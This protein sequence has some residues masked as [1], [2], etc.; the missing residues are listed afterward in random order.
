MREPGDGLAWLSIKELAALCNVSEKTARRWKQGTICPPP[1]ARALIEAD[2]GALDPKW[3]GWHL[4]RGVLLS[5]DG[6][7]ASPGDIM[8]L[9]F[10][11]L[12]VSTHRTENVRLRAENEEL[13]QQ[14]YPAMEDQPAPDDW[15]VK[16]DYG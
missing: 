8:A 4:R 12:Q 6:V 2:L 16:I 9:P 5:P 7:E 3:K 15:T 1:S 13:K 10:I 11:R 14:A